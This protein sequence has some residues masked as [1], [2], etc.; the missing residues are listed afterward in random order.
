[1][2]LLLF[3]ACSGKASTAH[4]VSSVA[5]E[6]LVEAPAETVDPVVAAS[7]GCAELDEATC[8]ESPACMVALDPVA[9]GYICRA[10][11]GPCE[12]G[13]VQADT[14]TCPVERDCEL[15][16]GSCYCPP[17]MTCI[18]GGGEPPGC[19]RVW[20]DRPPPPPDE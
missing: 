13:F 14:S 16:P 12:A 19:A 7:Q 15:V 4:P 3:F 6:P 11:S 2:S 8:F 10:A 1:M 9:Q 18:C 17:K 20:N 5:P